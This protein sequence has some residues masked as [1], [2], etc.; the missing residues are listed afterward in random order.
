MVEVITPGPSPAL[1]SL[2]VIPHRAAWKFLLADSTTSPP[3][4]LG[5]LRYARSRHLTLALNKPGSF[6]FDIAMTRPVADLIEP[7]NTCII[8]YKHAVPVWSGPIWTIEEHLPAGSMSVTAVGWL[9]LLNHRITHDVLHYINTV[10]GSIALDLLNLTNAV[11]PT[12]IIS[13]PSQVHD[14]QIRS[15]DYPRWQNVGAAIQE[16]SE[17]ENGF[18]YMV[19]PITRVLSF[20][21][22]PTL[23][24]SNPP[25][26][27]WHD[28]TDV[29]FGYKWGPDNIA[30]FSRQTDSSQMVNSIYVSGKNA[31]YGPGNDAASIAAYGAFESQVSL[32][33]IA[34]PDVL[35]AFAAEEITFLRTPRV[36]YSITPFPVGSAPHRV[37]DPLVDYGVGD[38]TYLTAK[39][40]PRVIVEGQG[41]RVFGMDIQ[42]DDEGNERLGPLQV[43]P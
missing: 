42:I 2:P 9:E 29:V 31:T 24:G 37:P 26:P 17:I 39:Y 11:S 8:A 6:S 20:W 32:S 41:V 15:R 30:D 4:P 14:T 38:Q 40:P 13:D 34:D 5:E 12:R 3:T 16:L 19:D 36:I 35:E 28:R 43:A 33:D 21:P 25:T 10:G 23:G 18:D 7:L 22:S 27:M 1:P